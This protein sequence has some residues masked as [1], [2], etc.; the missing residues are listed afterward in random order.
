MVTKHFDLLDAN[1][2]DLFVASMRWAENHWDDNVSLLW[3]SS[4]AK[5]AT[6]HH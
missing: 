6:L 5:L 3:D 4:D 1:A 2:R